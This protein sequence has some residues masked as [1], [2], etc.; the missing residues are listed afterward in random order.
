MKRLDLYYFPF[1]RQLT[2]Q[3]NRTD[4]KGVL[5]CHSMNPVGPREAPDAGMPRKDVVLSN[6]GNH[7]G[8]RDAALGEITCRGPVLQEMK[9]L[10]EN[11]G[12][13][14][15]LN[16]PYS[17]GFI[18]RHYGPGLMRKGGFAVQIEVNQ[19]LYIDPENR[20][21]LPEETAEASARI[22]KALESVAERLA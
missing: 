1:H 17:G 5:D 16:R 8:G 12:F 19:G 15:S 21:L 2:E 22:L 4:V 13:S 9:A 18:T 6:N 7:L 11:E 3:L 10:L 20:R 14:V